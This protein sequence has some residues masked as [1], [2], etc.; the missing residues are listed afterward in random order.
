MSLRQTSVCR[1]F[2]RRLSA[3][4]PGGVNRSY[5]TPTRRRKTYHAS[6]GRSREEFP[7][8]T[9]AD[10]NAWFAGLAFR[11]NPLN[12]RGWEHRQSAGCYEK[13]KEMFINMAV[14]S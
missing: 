9:Y 11:L 1:T 12:T 3:N 4:F 10:A 8:K 13:R 6:R 2:S 5:E 14:S 7:Y